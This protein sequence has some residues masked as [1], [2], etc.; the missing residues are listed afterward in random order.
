MYIC[1]RLQCDYN[2]DLPKYETHEQTE[3]FLNDLLSHSFLPTIY[4][5]TRII[6]TTATLIGNIF[7]NGVNNKFDSAI[8]YSD[9]S[10]H[11]PVVIH[12]SLKV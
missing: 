7:I 11:L 8:V 9:I 5:P 10:H 6:D 4:H 2:L 12:Y 3:L 1:K